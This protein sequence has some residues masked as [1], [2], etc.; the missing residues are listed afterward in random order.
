MIINIAGR[1][2]ADGVQY[3]MRQNTSQTVKPAV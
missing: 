1:S 3:G 2:S